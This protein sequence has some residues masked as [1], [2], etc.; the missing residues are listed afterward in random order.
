MAILVCHLN[1]CDFR[2][3]AGE[4]GDWT[5]YFRDQRMLTTPSDGIDRW[6]VIAPERNS[7]DLKNLM[8]SLF[9]AASGMGLRI[10]T[11]QE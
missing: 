5:R 4:S 6:A 7:Y 10:R 1:Q 3:S 8:D 11:P 9:R 2:V